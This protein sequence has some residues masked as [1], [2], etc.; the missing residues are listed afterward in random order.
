MRKGHLRWV[1]GG[2]FSHPA[3]GEAEFLIGSIVIR[4]N[5]SSKKK[6][7]NGITQDKKK[8]QKK[9]VGDITGLP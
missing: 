3:D 4:R 6:I 2:K 9:L 5:R 8:Q 1:S 7:T